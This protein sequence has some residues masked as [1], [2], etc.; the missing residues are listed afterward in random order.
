MSQTIDAIFDG[1]VFQPAGPVE[2]EPN[3]RVRVTIEPIVEQAESGT[4][5][6]RTARTL[7]LQGP[8][9]WSTHVEDYLY[10]QEPDG[11]G[12]PLP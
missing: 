9:D 8:A 7:N 11:N 4:S 2:L 3:T 10:D 5:F 12:Q 1:R 6:L